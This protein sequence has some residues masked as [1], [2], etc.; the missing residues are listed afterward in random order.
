VKVENT[1]QPGHLTND[2]TNVSAAS[3]IAQGGNSGKFQVYKDVSKKFPELDLAS[4]AANP[5]L[6][7]PSGRCGDEHRK[8]G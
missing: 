2:K 1:A 7:P 6:G 5:F 4:P 8:H 3:P